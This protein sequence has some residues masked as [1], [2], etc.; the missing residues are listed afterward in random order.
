MNQNINL[1]LERSRQVIGD[2]ALEN[3]AIVAANTDKTYY[4][5]SA[6]NYHFVW[7]RDAAFVC[8]AA[9]E[10]NL[11]IQEPFFKWLDERPEDFKK[12]GLIFQN[13]STNGRAYWRQF[14]PDQ[15]GTMLWA[16]W[17]YYKDD[18]I[19]ALGVKNLIIRLADGLCNNWKG[20][21]FFNNTFD[22]WESGTRKTSTKVE[23][24]HTYSLAACAKGLELA[25]RII[26][27]PRWTECAA[28]MRK[29][30]NEAY[31]PEDG[32]FLRNHGKLS[33]KNI[34]ASILGL[35]WPFNIIGVDDERMI[36]TVAKIEKEL[37]INGGGVQRFQFD[38][39]D[40]EGTAEEGAGAWP[41]LNFWLSI[42]Y[43]LKGDRQKAEFYFDW[44][45]NNI[46]KYNGFI[47]EQIF[48]DYRIGVYPLAWSHA[49][50]VLAA[51]KLGK[52]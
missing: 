45:I 36:K 5:R 6:A 24:N 21:Y 41:I 31:H 12:E 50:F 18:P 14:Q 17:E 10:L 35:V 39:Y 48:S 52:I 38:Y 46:K 8:V 51:K 30:I 4:P 7:P 1:I 33:D 40:G 47:P 34:D 49:M 22:L 13:Y 25:D 43:Q 29:K 37:V 9:Q 2:V 3:G 16:I 44:V 32:Y 27:Q 11:K 28:E 23:N 15:A 19:K 20:A 42:Y 26:N